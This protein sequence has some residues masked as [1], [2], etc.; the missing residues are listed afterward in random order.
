MIDAVKTI[1]K[2]KILST[3]EMKWWLT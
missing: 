1:I 2:V 3:W